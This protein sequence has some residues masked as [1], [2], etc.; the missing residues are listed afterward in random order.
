MEAVNEHPAEERAAPTTNRPA[1]RKESWHLQDRPGHN[2]PEITPGWLLLE[3]D[4]APT[5]KL[6]TLAGIAGATPRWS[7]S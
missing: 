5:A 6:D 4:I 7:H 2:P 1:E 3:D